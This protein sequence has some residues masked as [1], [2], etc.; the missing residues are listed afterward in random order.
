V[1]GIIDDITICNSVCFDEFYKINLLKNF[2]V[3]DGRKFVSE[4]EAKQILKKNSTLAVFDDY[5]TYLKCLE[6]FDFGEYTTDIFFDNKT[7]RK[8]AAVSPVKEYGFDKY[9]NIVAFCHKEIIRD[10]PDY[11]VF[12]QVEPANSD[13]YLLEINREICAK[14]F[15]ALKRK[16]RFDSVKGV[17][18]KYLSNAISYCQYITAV[19][20]FEELEFIRVKDKYE[21]EFD[22]SRK[23][24]LRESSV[25]RA[26]QQDN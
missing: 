2:S 7:S 4:T 25:Y 24:D 16:S 9:S 21:V 12:Y 22:N 13:L 5:E 8:T 6:V 17:Y 20:I 3:K 23:R 14:V 26:F 15:A 10:L 1:C 18:D 19:K 11:A